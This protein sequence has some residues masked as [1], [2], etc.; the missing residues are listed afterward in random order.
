ME[1]QL[2]R[3]FEV[4]SG[5]FGLLAEPTRL[6]ILNAICDGERSVSDI[7]ERV[8]STQTN[9]SRHLNLMYSRGILS[10]RREGAMTYY[11]ISDANVVALCRTACVHIA[12]G[13][14]E[15]TVSDGAVKRFMPKARGR[16]LENAR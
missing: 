3:L 1:P 16:R 13:F 10:R 5:Y 8:E 12:G 7:V 14:D 15:R 9:V 11:A 4:V 2:E 6:K